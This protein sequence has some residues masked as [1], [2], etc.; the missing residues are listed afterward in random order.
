MAIVTNSL[1]G[2]TKG[3]TGRIV[4]ANVNGVDISRSQPK[5]KTADTSEKQLLQQNKFAYAVQFLSFYKDFA[6]LYFGKKVRLTSPYN[7]AFSNVIHSITVN[8]NNFDID[9]AHILISKGNL[10]LLAVTSMSAGVSQSIDFEWYNNV[11]AGSPNETD[12]FNAFVY[13][14]ELGSGQLFTNVAARSAM[15]ATVA[16]IPYYAG[17]TVQVWACFSNSLTG[18][19]SKSVYLGTATLS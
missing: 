17:Q 16:M 5:P 13:C 10:P 14:P 12:Q 7:Q 15:S 1:L 4:I 3:R 6:K 8:D 19:A 9:Y 2:G 18:D 11:P